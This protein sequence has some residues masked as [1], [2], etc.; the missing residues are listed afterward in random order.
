MCGIFLIVEPSLGWKLTRK[1]KTIKTPQWHI[2][3]ASVKK[4]EL[5]NCEPTS[6]WKVK[7]KIKMMTIVS[8]RERSSQIRK[9]LSISSATT[10]FPARSFDW[11]HDS[12]CIHWFPAHFKASTKG[13]ILRRS[14]EYPFVCVQR[15]WMYYEREITS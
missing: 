12:L 6:G 11:L 2:C 4:S 7:R 15:W 9:S 5:L 13:N 8:S 1:M 14:L 10:R 3:N